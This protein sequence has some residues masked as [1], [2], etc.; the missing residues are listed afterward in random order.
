M[1]SLAL[2]KDYKEDEN[3][4]QERASKHPK[5]AKSQARASRLSKGKHMKNVPR[6][7]KR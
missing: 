2:L 7:K 1:L 3:R 5:A 6:G 4:A